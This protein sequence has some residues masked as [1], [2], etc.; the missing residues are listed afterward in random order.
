MWAV[1]G[2]G[3]TEDRLVDWAGHRRH[4]PRQLELNSNVTDN[5]LD[6]LQNILEL[7]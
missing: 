6:S 3:V 7:L 1:E 4:L 5:A 2:G